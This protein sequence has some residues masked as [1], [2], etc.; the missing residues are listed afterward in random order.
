MNTSRRGR[1]AI[2]IDMEGFGALYPEEDQI[3]LAFGQLMEG[4]FLV[5]SRCFPESPE[6]LF[7]HQ[8]GDGFIIVSEFPEDTLARAV[9]VAVALLRHVARTGRFATAC[10]AE[11]QFSDI[12]SC[13]PK[14]V[15]AAEHEPSRIALGRGVMTLLPVMGTALIRA[16]AVDKRRPKGP[17]LAIGAADRGRLPV[18]LRLHDLSERNLTIVDWVNSEYAVSESVSRIACL[19]VP[20]SEAISQALNL[21]CEEQELSEEWRQSVNSFLTLERS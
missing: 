12:H 10:I 7:V 9:A 13:Y 1:W 14:T 21:Y 8:L 15:L 11:G 5:G 3:L 19:N 16:V 2:Y 18:G 20:S 17:L 4:I 6:R